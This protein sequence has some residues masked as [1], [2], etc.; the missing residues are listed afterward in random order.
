MTLTT[1][2]ARTWTRG[3]GLWSPQHRLADGSLPPTLGPRIVRWAER[4]LVHGEGDHFGEPF[5][6]EPWEQAIAYR[7]W[8]YDPATLERLVR[9]ALIVLPKGCGKTELVGGFCDAELAGPV[10]PTADGKGALRKSP[11]IPVAAAS[12]EQADRLFS[13][14][15]TMLV[16]GPLKPFVE[17]YDTEILL[18]DRPGRLYR[19][20]AVAGTN[21]GTLPTCFGADEIH[22]WDGRKERVHLVIGNSLTKRAGGLELNISTPD[23]ADPESLFG[24]LHAYGL[25]VATGE[26]VD[27]SFLFVWFTAAE[28]WDLHD[29]VQL[30]MATAEATS[31]GWQDIDRIA[32]RLEVDRIP[33]HEYRRYHLAQLVRPEGQ[34]LP[35]DA[36]EGL[37]EGERGWPADGAEIVCFFDGSYNGDSTGLV[38][39]TLD[40]RPHL[41]VLGHWER[42]DG[43]VEWLVPREEVKARVAEVMRR[44]TVRRMGYDPFG[45]HREGEE[46]GEAYGD[47]VVVLW[48]TN[49]RKRMAAACSRFY[50]AVV[51]RAVS[52]DGHPGL[53][54]HLRNAVVKETPEGAYITKAGR[55]G[56]KIDLAVC[57]VGALEMAAIPIEAEQPFIASWR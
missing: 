35:P 50:T 1:P 51:Q 40:E 37:A 17:A 27:P 34:W 15:K 26:V 41:F 8:E 33:E 28:H 7:L 52:Q 9:R 44:F 20:A 19:V 18:K 5:V 22:E 48:E 3:S 31:A 11:N 23:A 21:D 13:A 2:L 12:F 32:A 57:A 4:N 6:F 29:P 36:W 30:R 46:W 45:W 39:C 49:L 43:T 56:P 42:P 16:E 47:D 25:K 24:R 38:G 55:G 14:A 54:R 53:A 10:V